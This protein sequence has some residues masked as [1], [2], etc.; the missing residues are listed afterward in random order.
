VS[1]LQSWHDFFVVAAQSAGTLVGLLFVGLSLHLRVVVSRADVRSLARVTLTNF[2]LVLILALFILIPQSAATLGTQLIVSGAVSLVLVSRSLV[3]AGLI[4]GRQTLG[5]AMLV[6]RFGL[7]VLSYVAT[8]VSGVM[9]SS[10][11]SATG[12]TIVVSV[13]FVLL[14]VSLRNSW[15]LLVSVGAATLGD[16]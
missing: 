4:E 1:S 15:D 11:S 7:S 12:V 14:V 6:V 5:A 3:A 9:F 10:G 13:S 8:I 16:R 2:A